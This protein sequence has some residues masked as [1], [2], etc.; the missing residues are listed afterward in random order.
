M[1]HTLLSL[2]ESFQN[3]VSL[4]ESL[5]KEEFKIEQPMQFRTYNISRTGSFDTYHYSFHGI[6]CRF[7]FKKTVVDYDYG[8]E[9][10]IDGFDLWRLT[11]YGVQFNEFKEFI[12][13]EELKN[14]F[15]SSLTSG[16]LVKS[17]SLHDNLYYL[18]LNI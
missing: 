11:N 2:I 6:G 5:L 1:N 15:N 3:K 18:P 7:Q 9:G 4:A 13:S 8:H 16:E 10:R 14:S 12:L 17:K